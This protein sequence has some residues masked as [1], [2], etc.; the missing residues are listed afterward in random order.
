MKPVNIKGYEKYY[1]VTRDGRVWSHRRNIFLKAG[2]M[3]DYLRVVLS[4]KGIRVEIFVHRLV[5]ITYTPNPENKPC[6]NHK[7]GDKHNN[8]VDNLEWV[9]YSENGKHAFRTGLI[10]YI[11]SNK[12]GKLSG[13]G[14]GR[15][16]V[17]WKIVEEIRKI[18]KQKRG[19]K[20]WLKYNISCAMYYNILNKRNWIK[21]NTKK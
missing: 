13:E 18:G 3:G 5:L 9:T 1:S 14:N 21:N 4:V 16:K 12:N 10:G 15:S 2:K 11:N 7:D 8:D 17:T 20:P 6:G 19:S